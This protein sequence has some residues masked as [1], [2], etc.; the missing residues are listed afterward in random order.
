MRLRTFGG[1]WLETASAEKAAAPRPRGLALLAILAAAGPKRATRDRI[2]GILWPESDSERARHALSQT[3]Y[4]LRR[5]FGTDVLS[6][7]DLRLDPQLLA[8]DI[9]DFRVA[10]AAKNWSAVA[11]LYVGPFLDGFYLGDAPEF[12]RWVEEERASLATVAIRAI[13]STAQELARVGQHDAACE[14]WRRLTRLDPFN[15]RLATSYMEALAAIDDRAGALAHGKL[16]TESMRKEFDAKPDAAVERLIRSLRDAPPGGEGRRLNVEVEHSPPAPIAEAAALAQSIAP[17]S[18]ARAVRIAA[19]VMATAVL[20]TFAARAILATRVPSPPMMAVGLIHDLVAPDSTALAG[21]SS[22]MLSTSLARI[23][24]LPVIA[25]S[26]M[27]ELM[28]RG[29]RLSPLAATDAARRAGA[30]EIIEGELMPVGARELR[31]E[32]RRV[33]IARGIVRAAY[34]VA[35]E[36]RIALFDSVASLIAAD[37]RLAAPAR[38]LAEVSTRS[39]I[40][41]RYYEEGLRA[42]YQFD[43]NAAARLFRAAV[44]EDSTFAMATYYAWRSAIATGDSLEPRLADRAVALASRAPPHDRLLILTHVGFARWDLR[45]IAAAET[46]ATN[47][48]RDPEALIRAAE[49]TTKLS[50]SVEYLNRSIAL[51]SAARSGV[52][53]VCRLCDA[54]NL[55]TT[56]YGWADSSAAVER[57]LRRWSALR[58]EDARPWAITADWLI[59]LGR[60]AEADAAVRRYYALGGARGNPDMEHSVAALRVDDFGSIQPTCDHITMSPAADDAWHFRWYC[61]LG[62]RIQGRYRDALALV[63]DGRVPGPRPT[64]RALPPDLYN[65]AILDFEMGR[66][67]DAADEFAR[68]GASLSDSSVFHAAG[69]RARNATWMSTLSAT[70]AV[71]VGDTTRARRLVDSI[72]YTGQRSLFARDPL[73]H[74]FVRGLLYSR[75]GQTEAAVREFRAAMDSPTFGYTRINYELAKSLLALNRPREGISLVQAALH[76]G[77]EGSG[78]YITRTELHELLARLFDATREAD[79]AAAHYAIVEA[80]WRTADPSFRSRYEAARQWLARTG[81]LALHAP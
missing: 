37:V 41:Y 16:Y 11:A 26:R 33:E 6:T 34:R 71:S 53:A 80:A 49:V 18:R 58:P 69:L 27:L 15:A 55:L 62:L 51:D 48:P 32:I 8:S 5:D 39:A 64:H 74:H 60:R 1:L 38:P 66:G 36:D 43:A 40:A 9:H 75:G 46:L 30:T 57:T 56:R 17:P 68:I 2:V 73:L 13:E 63:R 23:N 72:E 20:A 54:L 19:A 67:R 25:N 65:E 59:G 50:E 61:V 4:S 42:Y 3:I 31:L 10:V 22:E 21:V 35:G 14:Q 28:P 7:P 78:L 79:S 76:G 29:S 44:L 47:Y 52:A 70:A 24:G 45:A 81:R 12:E 77:I